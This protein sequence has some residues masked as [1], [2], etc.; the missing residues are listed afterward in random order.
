MSATIPGGQF[1]VVI[2]TNGSGKSTL[3]G[4]IAGTVRLDGGSIQ[5]AGHDITR[6][7]EDQRAALVGRVFQ[8]PRAGTSSTIRPRCTSHSRSPSVAACA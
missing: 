2:G 4:A 1:V 8:D 5:L 6:W 7:R 3:L